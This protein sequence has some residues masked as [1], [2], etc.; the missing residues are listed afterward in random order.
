MSLAAGG[1]PV[2]VNWSTKARTSPYMMILN[3][4]MGERE[5]FDLP[6]PTFE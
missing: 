6:F 3:N 5:F 2:A 4:L 1:A